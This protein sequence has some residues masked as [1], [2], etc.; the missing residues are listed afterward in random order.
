[1]PRENTYL[2]AIY[3]HGPLGSGQAFAALNKMGRK[4]F[5][6]TGDMNDSRAIESMKQIARA[7]RLREELRS[8]KFGLLPYRN[9]LMMDTYIDE[10]KFSSKIGPYIKY[11]SVG[12]YKKFYDITKTGEVEKIVKDIKNDFKIDKRVT[13]S[14]LVKSVK[15]SLGLELL[16]KELGLD[17]LSYDDVNEELLEVVGVSPGL[18]I[19]NFTLS[20][21]VFG[22]EG[23]IGITTGM[24]ILGK[25]TGRPAMM[26]EAIMFDRKNNIIVVGHRSLINTS[27]SKS[28]ND[29]TIV[30]DYDLME[31]DPV[32]LYGLWT[33]F[34]AKPGKVTL[35]NFF[36]ASDDFQIMAMTGKSLGGDLVMEGYPHM[37]IKLDMDMNLIFDKTYGTGL[38][39]HWAIVY[40]DVKEELSYLADIL[41]IK[42]NII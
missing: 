20:N 19:D 7:A 26:A 16:V 42:K 15:A 23:D 40:G 24:Y 27:F 29:I 17:A 34:K 6:V 28:R 9:D 37:E 25:I 21:L 36:N 39:H 2:D 41:G 35:L 22:T 11:I 18:F 12:Q 3:C 13:E 4:F 8:A 38:S 10:F 1:M 33:Q 30:P 31:E 14:D 5:L 32:K